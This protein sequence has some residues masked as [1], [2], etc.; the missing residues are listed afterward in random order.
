MSEGIT[1]QLEQLII[2]QSTSI[3][4]LRHTIMRV[5]QA[6]LPVLIQGPT[7]SGKELVAKAL[8]IASGRSG[9]FVTTNVCALGDTMIEDA[10]FGHVKGAFTGAASESK[11]LFAEANGGTIFLDEINGLAMSAQAKLLRV[12]ESGNFRTLGADRDRYSDF[13][14]VAACNE[15]LDWLAQRGKF[16]ADLLFRLSGIVVHVAPLRDRREDILVLAHHFLHG[17]SF[18]LSEQAQRRL[19]QHEWPGNVRELKHV[20]ERSILFSSGGM[21]RVRDIE[22]ALHR[23]RSDNVS[24]NCDDGGRQNLIAVLEKNDWDAGVAAKELGVHRTTIGR[25]IHRYGIVIPRE[26]SAHRSGAAFGSSLADVDERV[27]ATAL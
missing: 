26:R 13:R 15:G 8:H 4:A 27:T 25:R 17:A 19:Q 6:R 1:G 11:G 10:L 2:G 9:D 3:Q 5:A 21:I 22:T 7:G 23:H 16:R 20:L 14:V 18:E 24:A 12:I